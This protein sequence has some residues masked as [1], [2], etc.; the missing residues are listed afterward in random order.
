MNVPQPF[1][2]IQNLLSRQ[3]NSVGDNLWRDF[4]KYGTKKTLVQDWS[5]VVMSDKDLYTGYSFA[6]INNRANK[7]AQMATENINTDAN[8]SQKTASKRNE[9]EIV[10][11][12]LDIIDTSK[13]FSNHFFWY[14]ISTFLD[15][16]GVYY[17]MALRTVEG[18]RVGRVQEFKLLNPYNVRRIRN[19]DTGEVGGYVE[20]R[21]GLVRTIPPQM[22]IDIRNLNPFSSDDPYAMTDAAKESQFT[23][24]QAG[25]Y[26]RH[27]LKNNM[28]APG[29]LSTDMLLDTEQFENFVARVTNQEKGLPLFGNGA[30]AITWDAMQIDLDKAS[31]D[32]INEINRSTLFAVSGVGKTMMSIEESGTT[33]ETAKVQKDLFVEA[34]IMPQ[35]QLILD[36][37]NQ[38]YKKYYEPDYNRTG[39][40]LYID[41]PLKVDRD[42][43][44]KDIE[45]REKS[46]DIYNSLVNKGYEPELAAKYINGGIELDELG[47][48]TNEPIQP[49]PVTPPVTPPA[50]PEPEAVVEENKL[51]KVANEFDE[52]TQG[53]VAIQQSALQ[54]EVTRVEANIVTTVLNKLTS[55]QNAFEE[56]TDIITQA[57]SARFE[58]ELEE[59][60][61]SFYLAL[62]PIFASL[63]LAKRAKEFNMIGVF[64]LSPA[65]R[66]QTRELAKLVSN[67]HI[68]TVL[69]DLRSTVQNTYNEAVQ[70]RLSA[71]EATGRK[72]TDAD[73]AL[74]RAKALEG[75]GQTK[76][77]SA[78]RE[79]YTDIAKGRAKT[80][81]RTESARAFNQSQLQSDL[82]FIKQNGL[83]GRAYKKWVTYNDNP[84]QFCI[85]MANQ[86]PIPVNQN[87]IDLGDTLEIIDETSGK[88][89]VR[90]MSIDFEPV[91]AGLL[92]PNCGCRYR[93]IIE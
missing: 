84:C 70:A 3:Q 12:Y 81:A 80:I 24:K 58:K 91:D 92:H 21:D 1:K 55:A 75:N 43:E 27:S 57:D 4:L 45:I 87:F 17:L 30:G 14:S 68:S 39:Y 59:S 2:S 46:F 82:Q 9:T 73:L 63:F 44:M 15:L 40:K 77:V 47:L 10:H 61:N 64:K 56:T 22:I 6:A 35:L 78:V 72:V 38:D 74:A 28:A 83:E 53:L 37:L 32:K 88:P 8:D 19:K 93:L 29:I 54:N 13:S 89:K 11:P 50:T 42:A 18:E 51:E 85:N 86:P 79:K 31:L 60:L 7:L 69:E 71:I 67:S 36:G 62:M 48:P 33:R 26:T 41:N 34:H 25:D 52:E 49:E 5:K 65:I 76:I 23:L 66:R 90:K 20:S 16:E